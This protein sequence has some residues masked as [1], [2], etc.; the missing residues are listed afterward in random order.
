[1][2]QKISVTVDKKLISKLDTKLK[3]SMLRNRSHLVE[4]AIERFLEE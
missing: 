2:K 3:D 1:M 4:I